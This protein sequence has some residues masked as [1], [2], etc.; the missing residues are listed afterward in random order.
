M[1]SFKEF[2]FINNLIDSLIHFLILYLIF[3]DLLY[4][5]SEMNLFHF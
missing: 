4:I 5:R 1:S 2:K 3:K